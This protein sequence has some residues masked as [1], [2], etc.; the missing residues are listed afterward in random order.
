MPL[1]EFPENS[2]YKE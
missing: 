2:V 1:R